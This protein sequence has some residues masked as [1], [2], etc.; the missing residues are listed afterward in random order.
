MHSSLQQWHVEFRRKVD[1]LTTMMSKLTAQDDGQKKQF[2]PKTCH[3]QRRGQMRNFYDKHN[4]NQINDQS[5][6]RLDSRDRR[7]SFSGR[8][9]CG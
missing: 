2:K 6:Y 9:Q 1:R 7:I 4:Y 8:I 3:S 5:R